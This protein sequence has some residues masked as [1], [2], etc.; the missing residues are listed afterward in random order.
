MTDVHCGIENCQVQSRRL[1]RG[2]CDQH[3][4]RWWKY[5]DP[6]IRLK[7]SPNE[8]P[9]MAILIGGYTRV[10]DCY[11]FNG[12]KTA[13]G[14]GVITVGNAKAISAHR[15]SYITWF[16]ELEPSRV[17]DHTCHNE[18]ARAGTC[19]GGNTCIHRACV[20]PMHLR[21]I[22]PAEHTK[23]SPYT[24]KGS[25]P[26][27]AGA[28]NKAITHCPQGHEY[29]EENTYWHQRANRPLSR[30]CRICISAR[31]ARNRA[32]AKERG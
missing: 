32:K 24:A 19:A 16:G 20:N 23:A 27:G 31:S 28:R 7:R 8:N 4:T 6:T 11:L 18:A 3:Y 17:V 29:T 13:K 21:A 1:R 22:T 5:G 9:Y 30:E 15:V 12:Q 10:G 14:Y 2:M 25:A 26:S